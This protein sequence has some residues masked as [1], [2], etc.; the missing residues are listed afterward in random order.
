[1]I[2]TRESLTGESMEIKKVAIIGLGALGILFG[3]QIAKKIGDDLIIIANEKRIENYR[4]NGVYCN[5]EPCQFNYQTPDQAEKVDLVIFAVKINGLKDAIEAVR[6]VVGPDTLMLSLLNGITSETIIGSVLGEA[7]LIWV[8]AQGMDTLKVGNALSYTNTGMI[9]FGNRDD[10]RPDEKIDRFKHFLDQVGIAY[11]IDNR[12]DRKIWAKFMLNVGVN[13]VVSVCG[14]NFGSVKKPGEARELMIAAMAEVIPVARQE[15]VDLDEALKSFLYS[16]EE[17][18]LVV[19]AI[20]DWQ[21]KRNPWIA[22]FTAGCLGF[23]GAILMM[24]LYTQ[25][26]GPPLWQ[27]LWLLL[28]TALPFIIKSGYLFYLKR[29]ILKEPCTTIIGRNFLQWGNTMS[30]FNEREALKATDASLITQDRH[31]YVEILYRSISR[32]RYGCRNL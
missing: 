22:P 6:S 1:M 28:P 18:R 24:V 16:P 13:Q 25:F 15:G 17:T 27:W 23:M 26:S 31:Y 2:T 8:C 3:A 30:V 20:L 9:C 5:G 10:D 11:Q 12:M 19:A 4:S 14:E 29:L 7:N 21:K 32:L